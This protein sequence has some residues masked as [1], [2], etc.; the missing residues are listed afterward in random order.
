DVRPASLYTNPLE[1]PCNNDNSVN[2]VAERE[3]SFTATAVGQ[4][5]SDLLCDEWSINQDGVMVNDIND[6]SGGEDNE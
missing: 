3:R 2:P 6:V 5:D 4:I 1:D